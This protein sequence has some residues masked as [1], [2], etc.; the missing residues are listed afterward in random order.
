MVIVTCTVVV[1]VEHEG[2]EAVGDDEA[3]GV[4]LMRLERRKHPSERRESL[5]RALLA[6]GCDIETTVA[7][8]TVICTVVVVVVVEHAA[9]VVVG[10][11]E[12]SRAKLMISE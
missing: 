3:G 7:S 6:Y 5:R 4:D 1:V 12:A 2:G 9:G 8:F 11:N 10:D